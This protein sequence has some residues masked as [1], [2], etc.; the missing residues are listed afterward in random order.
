LNVR[1]ISLLLSPFTGFFHAHFLP[2]DPR[3]LI[4]VSSDHITLF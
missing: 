1:F 3:Q 2:F 4:L